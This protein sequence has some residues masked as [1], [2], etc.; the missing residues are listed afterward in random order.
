MIY[1][2]LL[3]AFLIG[4]YVIIY[5]FTNIKRKKN[6]FLLFAFLSFSFLSC[7]R[8]YSVGAD[9]KQWVDFYT[10]Y[11]EQ[12]LK[13]VNFSQPHEP[14]YVLLNVILWKISTNPRLLIIVGGLFINFSICYFIGKHS[15]DPFFSIL[16]WVCFRMFFESMCVFRQFLAMS[17]ILLSFDLLLNR[18][19][20][21]F[22]F[23]II[24][25]AMFHYF[26]LV[27]LL[28]IPIHYLKKLN[29]LHVTVVLIAFVICFT[30]LPQII[31]FFLEHV[32]NYSDYKGYLQAEGVV[33][34][35][36]HFQYFLIVF[37]AYLFPIVTKR[38]RY[39]STSQLSNSGISKQE[40]VKNEFSFLTII[41]VLIIFLIALS[42]RFI[43]IARI[44]DYFMPF[45][46]LIPNLVNLR[47]N[48]DLKY[49]YLILNIL[50]FIYSLVTTDLFGTINFE[51]F[52][53]V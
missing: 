23:T 4:C 25:A 15:K 32:S 46:T 9:T 2:V 53:N 34:G 31:D 50:Y 16:T 19:Y 1:Y 24:L 51:F 27:L 21:K 3:L 42:S 13:A 39:E 44:Y 10:I 20:I 5:K 8:A 49:Y 38:Y 43:L 17:I 37:L 11:G 47:K 18:K 45:V 36:F 52:W 48:K 41:Y 26:A 30:F 33:V 40:A 7:F 12:G 14:G 28:L 29:K 22:C 6:I 35:E